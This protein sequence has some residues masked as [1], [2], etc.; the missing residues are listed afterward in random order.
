MKKNSYQIKKNNYQ[1]K[2]IAKIKTIAKNSST[3]T[4]CN[5]FGICLFLIAFFLISTTSM[6]SQTSKVNRY[7]QMIAEGNID[8]VKQQLPELIANFSEEPGVILLQGAVLEDA[9]RAMPYYKKVVEKFPNSEWAPHAAWRIIQYYSIVSD[10]ATAKK[11]L[12]DFREKYPNS[13]FLSPATEA[14]RFSISDA[15]Y[16][17]REKYHNPP[18]NNATASKTSADANESGTATQEKQPRY[19]LQVAIYSTRA[20]AESE[21]DR[22]IKTARLRTEVLEK[23]IVGEK[24]YAVVI[25]DYASEEDA[26]IAKTAV[27]KQCKCSPLV[28]KK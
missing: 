13:A 20:A 26:L 2:I 25:G 28:F 22:F 19:G 7:L 15:R 21:K 9:S 11:A 23:L 4:I 27:E 6:L 24:K 18:T 10:T 3:N 16:G 17:N 12:N 5:L 14:V 1:S 8:E